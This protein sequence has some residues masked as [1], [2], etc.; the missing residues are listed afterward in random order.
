MRCDKWLLQ[1]K[2][3]KYDPLSYTEA[4]KCLLDLLHKVHKA[5]DNFVT[6]DGLEHGDLRLPNICFNDHFDVL[7]IDLDFAKRSESI[8]HDLIC[9]AKNLTKHIESLKKKNHLWMK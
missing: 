2:K 6:Y 9:F 7:L 4:N 3:V 5:I 1:Y 8:C